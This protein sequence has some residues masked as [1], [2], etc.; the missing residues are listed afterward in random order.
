MTKQVIRLTE[1]ELKG[2][3]EESVRGALFEKS[4]NRIEKYVRENEIAIITAWRNQFVNTTEKTDTPTHIISAKGKRGEKIDT[5]VPFKEEE[6]FTTTEK[7]FYNK[8]LQ[9][10]LLSYGYGVTKVRGRWH[11][12]LSDTSNTDDEESFFVVN[13]PHKDGSI[14]EK[15]KQHIFELSEK[16]NQDAFT[17][18]PKG[19]MKGY[20]IG[21]NKASWPGYGKTVELGD[22]TKNITAQAMTLVGNKGFSFIKDGDNYTESQ[23]NSFKL[24]KQ[25]RTNSPFGVLETIRS[26]NIV[27]RKLIM[28]E[29]KQFMSNEKC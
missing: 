22:F 25:Q 17:Y 5:K 16:A 27:A 9:A 1:S 12:E 18:S 28:E 13:L 26:Y 2:M 19:S 29:A 3:I 4:L 7:K 10:A 11:E 23:P 14:D 15:F 21:T 6:P 8:Q 20:A 24:R